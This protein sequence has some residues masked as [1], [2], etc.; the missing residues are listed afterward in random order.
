[1]TVKCT[2]YDSFVTNIFC[3][4]ISE[5][6]AFTISSLL[7][8]YANHARGRYVARLEAQ[9]PEST[10]FVTA[11]AKLADC[12]GFSLHKIHFLSTS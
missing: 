3:T 6:I 11:A 2:Q 4:D 10:P 1:M 7:L 8:H 9:H 12:A 5:R